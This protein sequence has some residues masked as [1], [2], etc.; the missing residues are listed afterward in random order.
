MSKPAEP[1]VS[2]V[3]PSFNQGR[4]IEE[5]IVSV[6]EQDYPAKEHLIFDACS[7]DETAQV[8]ARYRDQ[9]CATVEPDEGQADAVRKGMTAA[10]GEIVG[11][12]NSDDTYRPGAIRAAVD[13]LAAAPD[14]IGVFGEADYTDPGG[15]I[16]EPYPTA[17]DMALDV[18]CFVCQ[19]AVFVRK[20]ALER[21]GYVTTSLHFCMD[22][23]LWIRLR[24]IGDF[25]HIPQTLATSR[26]HGESKSVTGQLEFRREVV[27]MTAERLGA[28]PL[29]C[30][31]GYAD[32]IVRDRA[33][34]DL[35]QP[36]S[37]LHKAATIALTAL[38]M[39]RYHRRLSRR[40]LQ[41]LGAR[42]QSNRALVGTDP[43]AES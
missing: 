34:V 32:A 8:L 39:P 28:A 41:L 33:G 30:L 15:E 42:L 26:L 22:Y 20:A 37:A 16:I 11:W 43:S 13:A 40:D 12:L 7:T 3:T 2:I 10:R 24:Q 25:V 23:D 9:I 6:L 14:A 31:Y 36:V 5:T 19:P 4:F 17:P 35:E 29:T 38:L 18:G 21:V 27:G 1:L